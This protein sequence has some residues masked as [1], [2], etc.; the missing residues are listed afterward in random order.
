M[1]VKVIRQPKKIALIGAPTS[2]ASHS[3]GTEA[4]PAALRAAGLV[5]RLQEVGYE[6]ADMGDCPQFLYQ[7]DDESPRARNLANVVKALEALRPHVEHAIKSGALPLILGGDCT[8]ALATIAGVRRYFPQTGLLWLDGDADLNTPA[9][10]PSGCLAGMPVAHIAGRGAPELVRFWSEPPL[11]REP[12]IALFGV[13]RLDPPEEKLLAASPMRHYSPQ[14]IRRRGPAAAAQAA[15][16]RVH[17]AKK[18]IVLH[19]DVDV[20]SS[21]DLPATEFGS[22]A[23]LRRDE[24]GAALEVFA[25]HP[26]LAAIEVTAYVPARDPD[27]A[28]ARLLVEL[29]AAA[30]AARLAALAPP[31]PTEAPAAESPAPAEPATQPAPA[32]EPAEPAAEPA[33][34]AAEP[35]PSEPA[36]A[37]ETGDAADA[38]PP[39]SHDEPASAAGDSSSSDDSTAPPETNP[40]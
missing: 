13:T 36:F 2:A 16:E 19:L 10:T 34:A 25:R 24:V 9:T 3:A 31:Q 8:I 11:V 7:P 30:L 21:D 26:N 27:G 29:I 4:A 17:S 5:A 6:V 22:P 35:A 14:D 12:D 38:A 39:T 37:A 15:L 18:Q 28:G 23:G 32:A 40:Q 1:A 20:I 33:S